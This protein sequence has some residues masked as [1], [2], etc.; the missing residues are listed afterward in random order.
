MSLE[1]DI[2]RVVEAA[3]K[4]SDVVDTKIEDIDNRV[5]QKAIEIDQKNAVLESRLTAKEQAVDAKISEF[6]KALPLAPNLLVDTKYFNGIGEDNVAVDMVTSHSKPWRCWIDYG[7]EASGTVTKLTVG[8]LAENGLKPEGEFL[9]RALGSERTEN[10]FYGSNFK[11]LLF[12]VEIIKGRDSNPNEGHFFVLS[13]GVDTYTGW[14]RGEFLTQSS[15]W[16]NVLECSDGINFYPAANRVANIQ[17]DKSD[18]GK[19]WIYKHSTRTGWGGNHS[20][21]FSGKGRMKVAI[22][23]PYVGTGDHGNNMIWANDVG[24]PYSHTDATEFFN[25]NVKEAS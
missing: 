8:K 16:V 3:E 23:L 13:Q 5:A 15:C 1:Q 9:T 21:L 12:D 19:G 2:A 24:H 18:L 7:V 17:V 4:L 11:V 22:C 14:G 10:N 20:P 25:N 6:Q